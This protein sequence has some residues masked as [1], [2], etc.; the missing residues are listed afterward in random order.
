MDYRPGNNSHKVFYLTGFSSLG[1]HRRLLSIPFFLLLL[2]MT[3][4]NAVVT[5]VIATQKKLYEPMYVLIGSLTLLSF[6][7][8]IFFLPRMVISFASGRN[9]ITKEECLIQMFLIH[10]GGSF[11]SSILLQMAVD[12]FFAICWPLRY[13][14]IVNLRNSMLFSA[15][16]AL[17][18]TLTIVVAVCLFIPHTFC[19]TNTIYHCLCEHTSVVKLVCG[20]IARNLV[21]GAMTFSLTTSDC[22][23]VLATYII[24]FIVIFQSPSGESRQKAIHTCSTHLTVICVGYVSVVCAFVGYRVSGIPPD[25]RVL[26]TLSYLIIPCAFNPVIYGIR[27]KEIKVH[28]LKLLKLS[29]VDSEKT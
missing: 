23:L 19:H 24:I 11:Q 22:I 21:A 13:H 6:F 20:N 18:N 3:A 28:V 1:E 29:K 15:A 4:A 25:T 2:Y 27:T 26:L 9:E 14:N 5:F 12:R 16:L 17:R 7:Y 10:F 8:P